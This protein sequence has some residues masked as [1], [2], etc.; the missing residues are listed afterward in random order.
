MRLNYKQTL[1]KASESVSLWIFWG[2]S[3]LL[4]GGWL[5]L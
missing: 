2:G 3:S 1:K 4:F 5:Q